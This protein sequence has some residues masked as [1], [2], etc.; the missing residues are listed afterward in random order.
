MIDRRSFLSTASQS[1]IGAVVLT[2]LNRVKGEAATNKLGSIGVQL[3]TVRAEMEKDFEG[4]LE[5]IAA[6]GYKEVEF[7]G[8]YNKSPKDIQAVL[9]RCGLTAPSAHMPLADIQTK[10]DQTV[11][12][13]KAV[14][15]QYM[16]CPYLEDK[17]RRTLDDYKRHAETFNR[18]G[19]ACRK[20]GIQ[21]GYHNHNFEFEAKDD[22]LPYDLLLEETDKDL[23]KM[24][25]DLYWISKAGQD[26]IAYIDLHK[27]R[28]VLFHVKDMDKTPKRGIT[29][30]GRGVIDFKSIFAKAPKGAI[31]HYF[32]EQDTCP[33]SPFDSIKVSIDYLKQLE[34]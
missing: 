19:E 10:L 28:F 27:D 1:V 24:E 16:I 3:Y 17:D 18:A 6:I 5:K 29:E 33:G 32:V 12:T 31:K 13:V 14:G 30:V 34:F 21:F 11:E 26:P 8:Y 7:A 15:H 4:S 22:K 23:V 25:L 2:A 9:N 20:A